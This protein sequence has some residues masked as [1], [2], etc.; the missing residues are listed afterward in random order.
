MEMEVPNCRSTLLTGI[1]SAW[2]VLGCSE[3]TTT[4]GYVPTEEQIERIEIGASS[5]TDVLTTIGTPV[6]TDELYNKTWIYTDIVF[7]RRG[8]QAAEIEDQAIVAITFS[9]DDTVSR[10]D[11]FTL[12]EARS[13]A[14]NADTTEI[15]EGRLSIF[16][17]F[18]RAFGRVDPQTITGQ[19]SAGRPR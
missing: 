4:H 10:I 9:D 16:D 7:T 2:M 1:V 12:A 19:S 17:Q 6:V 3:I 11:R 5:T 14:L 8:I 18:M 13:I 15:H